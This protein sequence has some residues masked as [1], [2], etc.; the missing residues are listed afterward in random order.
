MEVER[1]REMVE[2]SACQREAA[3]P[4]ASVFVWYMA[5]GSQ[6]AGGSS[7]AR[8]SR[9]HHNLSASMNKWVRP[10]HSRS[11]QQEWDGLTHLFIEADKLWWSRDCRALDDPPANCDPTAMYQTKTDP[12]GA[13]ASRWQALSRS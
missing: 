9:D 1:S 10:S 13:A 11:A 8:Q 5:V 4:R 2:E 3:A 6:L 12:L 7:S